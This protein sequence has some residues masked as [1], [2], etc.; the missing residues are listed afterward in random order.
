MKPEKK[1]WESIRAILIAVLAALILRQFVIAAYKIPTSS[2]EDT[3][4][5]GDFLLVNKFYYGAQTPNW[6]GIPF[7]RIGFNIP[8]IRFP[9]IAEVKQNDI[10]VFRYP[11]DPHLEYIKRCVAVGGQ[12]VEVINKVLYVDG[13]RFPDPPK[14]KHVDPNI[15]SR[16]NPFYPTFRP[17]LGSRDNFGPVTVPPHHYFMMGD[18]RDRSSDSREWG[19]VPPENIV[20][21]PL[22]IY[23]SWDSRVPGYRL[24]HKIR[25]NRLG[26]VIR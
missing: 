21:R 23:L 19:F 25:W 16:D 5:V 13:K 2:M 3:L 12:T 18:N 6:I 17:G 26:W 14:L 8:W 15:F 24:T 11:R 22:I 4:L 1:R 9:K 20:G 10:V 7:T